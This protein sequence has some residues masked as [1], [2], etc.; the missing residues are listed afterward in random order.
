MQWSFDVTKLLGESASLLAWVYI[1]VLV[2][3]KYAEK[4]KARVYDDTNKKILEEVLKIA[5][6]IQGMQKILERE[7]R[8]AVPRVYAPE[9]LMEALQ[10]IRFELQK[11]IMDVQFI[12]RYLERKS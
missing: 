5:L 1:L 7:G 11:Y 9:G 4:N 8:D 3:F 2:W 10:E 6:N 12:I